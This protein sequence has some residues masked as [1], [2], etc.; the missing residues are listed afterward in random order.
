MWEFEASVKLFELDWLYLS[1]PSFFFVCVFVFVFVFV[2]ENLVLSINLFWEADWGQR[3]A[4]WIGFVVS[5]FAFVFFVF[6]FVFGIAFVF[7]FVFE[8][9][10][11][12]INLLWEAEWGKRG[13]VWIG[14]FVFVFVFVFVYVFVFVFENLVLSISCRR[15]S[16][17]SAVLFELDSLSLK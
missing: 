4:V 15:L 7:D 10:V 8:N 6:V 16:E 5:V 1:L 14:F 13:A 12:S 3:G 17:A 2:F 9:L 11:L